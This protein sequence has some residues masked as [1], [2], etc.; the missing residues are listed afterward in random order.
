MPGL[1]SLSNFTQASQSVTARLNLRMISSGRSI[2]NTQPSGSDLDILFS[3]LVRL[4]IRAPYTM[5]G[6]LSRMTQFKDKSSKNADNINAGLF[7]YPALM[8]AD[9]LLYQA[10]YV[11][12]A[13]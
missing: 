1:F 10:D 3:G 4:M 11:P 5:F 7:T 13:G 9:I 8:A 12:R 2:R 6:E